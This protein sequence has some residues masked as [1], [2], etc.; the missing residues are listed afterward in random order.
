M[1]QD[2]QDIMMEFAQKIMESNSQS[3]KWE[4]S[5]EPETSE[6]DKAE[7]WIEEE[8]TSSEK[9]LAEIVKEIKIPKWATSIT[10]KLCIT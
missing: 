7:W 10:L 9:Y 6:E 2:W 3:W 8:W 1:I 4:D 5:L